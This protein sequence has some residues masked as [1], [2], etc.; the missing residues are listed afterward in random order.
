MENC[1]FINNE[2]FETALNDYFKENV[3]I[4]GFKGS[5]AVMKGDNYTSDTFKIS[6][7]FKR[8]KG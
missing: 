2:L 1:N 5:T 3:E 7:V 8:K 6:V 4:V